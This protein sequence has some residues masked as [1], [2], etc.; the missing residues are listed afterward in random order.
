MPG[1]GR[2]FQPGDRANPRGRPR[3]VKETAPRGL[4]KKLT[5]GALEGNEQ[6]VRAALEHAATNPKS[7]VQVLDLAAKLN[8]EVGHQADGR[9]GET[10]FHIAY[11]SGRPCW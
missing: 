5:L 3:G 6:A 1:R 8:K 7:V 4:I 10:H 11:R 9:S 2:P